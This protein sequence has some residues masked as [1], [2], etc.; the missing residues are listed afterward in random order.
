MPF[1]PIDG[2]PQDDDIAG[3]SGQDRIIALDGNDFIQGFAGDDLIYG[4]GGDDQGIAGDGNDTVHGG[5]GNDGLNG[6][7]GDDLLYG[8]AGDDYLVGSLGDDTLYGG[9]GNDLL[10]GGDFLND[11][12][13]QIFGGGGND[14]VFFS[15]SMDGMA[16]GGDGT[17]LIYL[18]WYDLANL[19]SAVTADLQ[20]AARGSLTLT[21]TQM[22]RLTAFGGFGDDTLTGGSLADS[23]YGNNGA[24][25]LTGGGGDDLLSYGVGAAN[26]LD[27]GSGDD[28]LTLFASGSDLVDL[29]VTGTSATDS[30]GSTITRIEQFVV[31][32]GSSNDFASLGAGADRFWGNLGRD[33]MFGGAGN[34]TGEGGGGNDQL[35]GGGGDDQLFGGNAADL[36]AGGSGADS[37]TGGA[38]ADSFRF[39]QPS[40]PGDMI[41]DFESG[42]D[43]IW[44]AASLIGGQI[45]PGPVEAQF[46][47]VGAATQAHGQFVLVSNPDGSGDLFWDDDGTGLAVAALITGFRS[48]PALSEADILIL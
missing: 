32:C 29:T 43:H 8:G 40:Q 7:A 22:E 11:G 9:A 4:G 30:F 1:N 20:G 31:E 27:G 16:D 42:V 37:L 5:T 17:D 36:L 39:R 46:F 10:S 44:V 3:T 15:P 23:L 21:F 26:L 47:A 45:T 28:T 19:F 24:N 12:T 34:D 48:L 14:S 35:R 6:E 13:K 41:E 18:Q 33:T 25:V 2:S 38:G